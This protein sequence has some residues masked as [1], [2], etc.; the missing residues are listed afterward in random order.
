VTTGAGVKSRG[1]SAQPGGRRS[2]WELATPIRRV[3]DD[4]SD[5]RGVSGRQGLGE[6]DEPLG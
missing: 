2:E 5:R 1:C 6:R 4:L 3:R